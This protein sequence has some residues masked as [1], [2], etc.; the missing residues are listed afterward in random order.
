MTEGIEPT[1][2][3]EGSAYKMPYGLPLSLGESL[4]MLRAC[5]PLVGVL[6]ERFTTAHGAVKDCELSAFQ[7]VISS[8]EREFLLR[9]V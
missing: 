5:R 1:P 9:N 8:W 4:R 7:Q 6:G 2:A 3:V